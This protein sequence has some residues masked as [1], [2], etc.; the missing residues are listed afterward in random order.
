MFNW[1]WVGGRRPA[2]GCGSGKFT[3]FPVGWGLSPRGASFLPRRCPFRLGHPGG[4]GVGQLYHAIR[5]LGSRLSDM[6]PFSPDRLPTR[7][8]SSGGGA[9][10][11]TIVQIAA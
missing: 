2:A 11:R 1:E 9:M 4:G 3:T 7:I 6:L 10:G 8:G 5:V